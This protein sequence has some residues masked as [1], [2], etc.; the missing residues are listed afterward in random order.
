MKGRNGVIVVIM[1]V[2]AGIGLLFVKNGQ[3]GDS[4]AS[5]AKTNPL[6]NLRQSTGTA[7]AAYQTALAEAKK[8]ARDSFL[9]DLDTTGVQKDGKSRTWYILFYSPSK[10][11]NFKVN[12]VEGKIDRTVAADKKKVAEIAGNWIDSDQAA[13]IALPKCGKVSEEDYF[14]NLRVDKNGKAPVWNFNCK[15]GIYKTLIIDVNARTGEYIKTRKAG[16]G[17]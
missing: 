16:I 3:T 11:T 9:V 7:K 10:N 17:W 6:A 4:A 13:G 15:V 2:L 5:A 8:F 14:I 12:V 1:L